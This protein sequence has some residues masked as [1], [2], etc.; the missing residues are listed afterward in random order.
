M[1]TLKNE[2]RVQAYEECSKICNEQLRASQSVSHTGIKWTAAVEMCQRL[3]I[4][5]WLR[6]FSAAT[7]IPVTDRGVSPRDNAPHTEGVTTLAPI[8]DADTPG[9]SLLL[10]E[11]HEDCDCA[12]CLSPYF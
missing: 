6:G 5:A 4:V 1:P 10:G 8:S 11:R 9:R 12:S 2:P 3:M 7:E